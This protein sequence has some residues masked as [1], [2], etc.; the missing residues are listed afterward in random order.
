[1]EQ[2]SWT[3][4]EF[5]QRHN[6]SLDSGYRMVKAKRLPHVRIGVGRGS[7]RITAEHENKWLQA[8]EISQNNSG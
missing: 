3:L 2:K 1:M 8:N 5:C 7:I 4:A 6:M